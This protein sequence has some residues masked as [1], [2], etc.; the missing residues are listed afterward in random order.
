MHNAKDD[1]NCRCSIIF[2][3]NGQKPEV[4]RS[5]IAGKNVVIPY[6]TYE[7]WKNNLKRR[8]NMAKLEIK[9]TEEAQKR[10]EESPYQVPG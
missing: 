7:E 10:K 3:V 5:R 9:L 1:I 2:I 6:T 4:R 8:G